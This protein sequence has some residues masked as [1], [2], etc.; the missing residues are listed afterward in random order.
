MAE[1]SDQPGPVTLDTQPPEIQQEVK[2]RHA[3]VSAIPKSGPPSW[4]ANHVKPL[5]DEVATKLKDERSPSISSVWRWF[6]AFWK[7]EGS[8]F[9]LI[10][11]THRQG[12][13]GRRV[14]E[15]LIAIVRDMIATHYLN[16]QRKTMESVRLLIIEEID[17]YNINRLPSERL[18]HPSAGLMSHEVGKLDPYAVDCARLGKVAADRKARQT[19]KGPEPERPYE[20]LEIDHTPGDLMVI[21]DTEGRWLPLGRPYVTAATDRFSRAMGGIYLGFV[22]PSVLSAMKCLR[23]A[24]LPKDEFMKDFPE[25]ENP[26]PVFGRPESVQTDNGAEFL[27]E[28]W[29]A[30]LAEL[31]ITAAYCPV[32]APRYKGAVERFFR[33]LNTDLLHQQPGTTFSNLFDR[34]DYDPAKNAVITLSMLRLL[35]VKYICDEFH[36]KIHRT[37]GRPPLKLWMEGI[38][39]HPPRLPRKNDDL[40]LLFG[41]V[42]RRGVHHYGI[43]IDYLFYNGD[44]LSEVRRREGKNKVTV[45]RDEEDLGRIW[46]LDRFNNRYIEVPCTDLTYAQG[47]SAWQHKVIRARL[48][49]QGKSE[50]NV[51]DLARAKADIQ[52]IVENAMSAHGGTKRT[53]AG[54]KKAARWKEMEQG[55]TSN[56]RRAA[57]ARAPEAISFEDIEPEIL[58]ARPP[59]PDAGW[60][61]ESQVKH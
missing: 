32:Q 8:V 34:D 21:D 49:R 28:G 6:T 42:S 19:G 51:S 56:T 59:S 17:A 37:T 3:Y 54:M 14:P 61:V 22:P 24:I 41:N 40:V 46:V 43:Q 7:A 26:W 12:R 48:T 15:K 10:P 5:I 4:N 20:R 13:W 1:A 36:I 47:L 39:A 16:S 9:A 18:P 11:N 29:K 23:H 27:S 33:T 38:K 57:D 60:G 53:L 25:V 55:A 58:T 30:T 45:R 52:R 2:R 44:V 35:I 31:G 50:F